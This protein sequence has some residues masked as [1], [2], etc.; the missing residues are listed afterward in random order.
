MYIVKPYE[1]D[2]DLYYGVF[3]ETKCTITNIGVP[4]DDNLVVLCYSF[5]NACKIAE[6]L[7]ED[8]EL[9]ERIKN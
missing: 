1:K 3:I 7:E 2:H 8:Q 9:E 4:Y 6:L 5:E